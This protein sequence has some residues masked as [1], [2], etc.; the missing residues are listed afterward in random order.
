MSWTYGGDPSASKTDE[1]RFLIGDT[2]PKKPILQDEEI[3]YLLELEGSA[4]KAASKAAESAAAKFACLV[5]Q[6]AG[7]V[8]A[9]L[10]QKFKHY[11]DLSKKLRNDAARKTVCPF[12]GGISESQKETAE[13][14][15]DRVEPFF[16][17][18]LHDTQRHINDERGREITESVND[19]EVP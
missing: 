17:R 3:A 2:N 6:A 13:R 11:T 18:D 15:N 14:D 5:D 7:K 8:R 4:L 10:S 12:A 1:V 9:S 19:N 16:T